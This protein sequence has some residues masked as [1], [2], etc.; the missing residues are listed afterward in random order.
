MSAWIRAIAGTPMKRGR[1][2]PALRNGALLLSSLSTAAAWA[3]QS[4]M[5]RETE[6]MQ[7]GSMQGGSPPADARDPDAYAEGED[8]GPLKPEF[9]DQRSFGSL[10]VENLEVTRADGG[11]LVPYD[12]EAWF[13]PTFDRAV[14]KAEGELD[15]SR[16]EEARSELLWGHAFAAFWDTQLGIRADGG[17][18]PSRH[19]IAFGVEGLSPYRF[20]LEATA[21]VGESGRS[22]LRFD[23]SY[24]FLLTQK[25]VLQPRL[26]VNAYGR[27]DEERGLGNG[28]SDLT[29]ALRLRYEIRREVAP[30]VG[31]ESVRKYGQTKRIAR[32]AG[33]VAN[34]TRFVAGVRFW[35]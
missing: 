23:A 6:S 34:D 30:Y 3:Q 21:Y 10:R 1:R 5:P 33:D 29:A 24:E 12:I 27:A 35:F 25:L 20:D 22:A 17:D 8:F 11:T 4:A 16:V 14:L 28:F 18:G 32:A 13:G 9:A 15:G 7:M 19:W 26:E 31:I 2:G